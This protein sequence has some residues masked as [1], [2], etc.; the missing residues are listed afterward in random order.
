MKT[1]RRP[2]LP[3]SVRE[4]AGMTLPELTIALS[5]V[6][7]ASVMTFGSFFQYQQSISASRAARAISADVQLAKGLAIRERAPVSLVADET[8]LRYVIRDT[9]GTLFSRRDFGNGAEIELTGLDFATSGDSL[10]F[11]GRGVLLTGGTPTVSVTRH[12]KTRTVTL[13]GLGRTQ[14]N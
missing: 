14:I 4:V 1:S 12:S 11:D 7:I 6:A 9:A 10:T 13:N 3:V 8:L 5:L 2:A